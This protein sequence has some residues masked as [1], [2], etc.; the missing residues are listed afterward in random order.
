M[1]KTID[2][3]VDEFMN[4]LTNSKGRDIATLF[5][6]CLTD[7][8]ADAYTEGRQAGDYYEGLQEGFDGIKKAVADARRGLY[9]AIEIDENCNTSEPVNFV[10]VH[11]LQW[12]KVD[13]PTVAFKEASDAER[14]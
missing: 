10:G 14:E 9:R 11:P 3:R 8:V 6:E 13:P 2:E 12:N 7:A 1:S 5:E 4:K